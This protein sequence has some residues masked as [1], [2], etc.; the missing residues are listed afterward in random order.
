MKFWFP[1]KFPKIIPTKNLGI[2]LLSVSGFQILMIATCLVSVLKHF[3]V[4][5]KVFTRCRMQ[6]K[7]LLPKGFF[8]SQTK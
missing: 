8:G 5:T 7:L 1:E 3:T 4:L 6:A 2:F